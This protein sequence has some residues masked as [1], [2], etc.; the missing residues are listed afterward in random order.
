MG[1]RNKG[2]MGERGER[3]GGTSWVPEAGFF[4]ANTHELDLVR[5][6]EAPLDYDNRHKSTPTLASIWS[7]DGPR[8]PNNLSWAFFPGRGTRV[9]SRKP[10]ITN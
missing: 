9:P 3:E 6:F 8:V 1:G 7:G 2:E 5:S 10:I 4:D